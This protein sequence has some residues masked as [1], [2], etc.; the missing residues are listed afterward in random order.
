MN[1]FQSFWRYKEEIAWGKIHRP[2]EIFSQKRWVLGRKLIIFS[3]FQG[4]IVLD[5]YPDK[6]STNLKDKNNKASW[7][8]KDP[9]GVFLF[10]ICG[11]PVSS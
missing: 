6:L 4:E 1:F 3:S 8:S 5:T 2:I 9:T 11:E 7:V 10:L